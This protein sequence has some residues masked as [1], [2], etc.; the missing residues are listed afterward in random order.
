MEGR[1]MNPSVPQDEREGE[2]MPAT[3]PM[4]PTPRIP[5]GFTV[6][7]IFA[8][9]SLLLHAMTIDSYGWFRDEFYYVACGERPAFGYV[10]HPPLVAWLARLTRELLGESLAAIRIPAILAG[11]A[12]VFLAGRL[13]RELGGRRVAQAVACSCVVIAPVYLFL[14]HIYS[15]NVFEVLLWTL[16]AFVVVRIV[17]TGDS[18]LW[19]LFGLV[20]GIG[21]ETKHSMLL[22]GFGIFAGVVLTAERRHLAR[23]WIWLGGALAVLLFLPN[24]LWQASHGW[25]TLEFMRNAQE[26]KNVALS[27]VQLFTEQITMMHPLALPVWLAG[28]GW[29]LVSRRGRPFRLFGWA[30]LAIF[31]ALVTQRSKP[32]YLAPIFPV[33]FAAGGVA[34]ESGLDRLRRPALRNAA[35]AAVLALLILG[36]AATAPL[37]LPILPEEDFIVYAKTLGL[38]AS[39][40][41]RHEM[42]A[43]PQHFADMHGWDALVAE[44]ARVYR[45]LPPA[46]RAGA[47]IYVQNYGEAGA[48]DVLGRKLGLPK[49]LSGHNSYFLWGPGN[50]NGHV[51]VVLGGDVADNRQACDDLRPVG[52][53]RCGLCMP[54]EDRQ[55]VYLCRGLKKPISELWPALKRYI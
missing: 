13:A 31:A 38:T 53:V 1:E 6:P 51:L 22:F 29:C 27:P 28:L 14:F 26:L 48:L 33:L 54:Y 12:V 25:P 42:G 43:L 41:E 21:L 45:S 20:A 10:D 46:E 18:R 23:P 17:K 30:F 32:Y 19:L 35:A 5:L 4:P 36:G 15:M 44:V 11:A 39:S 7:G 52:E 8:L 16:G 50:W 24:L 34:I 49:P 9:L 2:P 40:G 55:P 3:P 37:A 47:G